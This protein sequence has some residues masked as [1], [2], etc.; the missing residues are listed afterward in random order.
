MHHQITEIAAGLQHVR[1]LNRQVPTL[2]A[3]FAAIEES[4]ISF[5]SFLNVQ[6]WLNMMIDCSVLFA[7]FLIT[8]MVIAFHQTVSVVGVAISFVGLGAFST[9]LTNTAKDWTSLRTS[10]TA[11]SR[12]C[13]F[14]EETPREQTPN[15]LQVQLPP[16]W[17]QSGSIEIK[18]I[19][20]RYRYFVCCLLKSG[21][22]N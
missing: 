9:S 15:Q 6:R 17:P 19:A 10:M 3:G 16:L 22:W 11:L 8:G 14:I 18:N 12:L 5:Y 7:A 4:Q 21:A 1:A 2:G 13:N 20:A